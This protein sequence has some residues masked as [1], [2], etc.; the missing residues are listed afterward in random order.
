M[1]SPETLRERSLFLSITSPG[2]WEKEISS[3]T[4]KKYN[5]CFEEKYHLSE[6]LGEGWKLLLE[7]LIFDNCILLPANNFFFKPLNFATE[8]DVHFLGWRTV[9][10]Y[11]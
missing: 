5:C 1:Y 6:M 11:S 8:N 4:F 7:L 10:G 3:K 9:I 2:A